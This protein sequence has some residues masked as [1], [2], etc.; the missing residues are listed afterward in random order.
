LTTNW[1]TP[2][3]ERRHFN[4][5]PPIRTRRQGSCQ[6]VA[7]HF[8]QCAE[9]APLRNRGLGP[10][11]VTVLP[12][13]LAG[14]AAATACAA[15]Q[16][17]A[18]LFGRWRPAGFPAPGPGSTLTSFLKLHGLLASLLHVHRLAAHFFRYPLPPRWLTFPTIARPPAYTCTCLT[19]MFCS[20]LRLFLAKASTC[21]V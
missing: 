6:G 1:S 16:S 4:M 14:R 8:Q 19:F 10:L 5:V 9:F 12:I 7:E 2:A 15:V 18:P 13:A 20:P 3:P 17:A 11:V 21:I